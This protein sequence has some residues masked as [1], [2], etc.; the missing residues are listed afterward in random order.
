MTRSKQP[1]ITEVS[2]SDLRALLFWAGVGVRNSTSGSYGANIEEIIASYSEH[3]K[4]KIHPP[5]RF[6]KN[7]LPEGKVM[8]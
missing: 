6:R 4:F 2:T 1:T 5:A 7:Q 8:I 3:I